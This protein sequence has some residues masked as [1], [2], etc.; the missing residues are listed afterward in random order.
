MKVQ[1][2][3]EKTYSVW[4]DYWPT[5]STLRPCKMRGLTDFEVLTKLNFSMLPSAGV[6]VER[7]RYYGKSMAVTHRPSRTKCEPTLP[8]VSHYELQGAGP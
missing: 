1:T 5:H 3:F 7:S 8:Y 2:R 4:A 6:Y